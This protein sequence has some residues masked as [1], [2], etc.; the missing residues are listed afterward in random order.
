[1]FCRVLGIYYVCVCSKYSI[2][3][4]ILQ[5]NDI[6]RFE[7]KYFIST[8]LKISSLIPDPDR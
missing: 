6:H 1:M 4:Q 5:M 2:N 7:K 3:M 8:F